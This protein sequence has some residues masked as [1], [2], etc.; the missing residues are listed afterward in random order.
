MKIVIATIKSWNIERAIALKNKYEGIHEIIIYTRK[1]ELT[2]EGLCE[3]APDYVLFP[4]WSYII[5]KNITDNFECVVFHMTDLPY[6][7]GGSPLHAA[8][9]SGADSLS[10]RCCFCGY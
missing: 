5:P 9:G 4:H 2:Y 6:G 7:R 8:D 3:A 1:E 10:G